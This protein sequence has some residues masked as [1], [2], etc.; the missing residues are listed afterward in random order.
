LRADWVFKTLDEMP[1]DF[2]ARNFGGLETV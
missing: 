1:D 2:F